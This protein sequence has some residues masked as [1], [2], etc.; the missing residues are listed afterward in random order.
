[1]SL[2]VFHLQRSP[3][4]PFLPGWLLNKS[5]SQESSSSVIP[6]NALLF[7]KLFSR[8]FE[9]CVCNTAQGLIKPSASVLRPSEWVT[10]KVRLGAELLPGCS[11]SADRERE[12]AAMDP[13]H[14]LFPT[15]QIGCFSPKCPESGDDKEVPGILKAGKLPS[16]PRVSCLSVF[17]ILLLCC[18]DE[19]HRVQTRTKPLSIQM[20]R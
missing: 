2:K 5:L 6:S 4:L 15:E 20:H 10:W 14:F 9:G 1:M 7:L 16:E 12:G 18:W 17:F 8:F 13:V 19:I 11:A 3:F